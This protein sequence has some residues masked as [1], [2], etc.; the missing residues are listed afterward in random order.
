MFSKK[1]FS[2]I[3]GVITTLFA[4]F[5]LIIKNAELL[6]LPLIQLIMGVVT[7]I[8]LVDGISSFRW[9]RNRL[10]LFFTFITLF[11]FTVIILNNTMTIEGIFPAI[12]MYIVF[13]VPIGIIALFTPR[14]STRDDLKKT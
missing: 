9:K 6:L 4:S 11:L 1:I 8:T 12:A 5:A 7:A 14:I 2:I 13:G 10:G 3:I